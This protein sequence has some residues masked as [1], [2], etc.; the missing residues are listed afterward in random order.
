M[1]L[2][3]TRLLGNQLEAIISLLFFTS[4]SSLVD[5]VRILPGMSDHDGIPLVT[6]NTRP[7]LNKSK[8]RK[9]HQYHK[10]DWSAIKSDLSEISRDFLDLSSEMVT[11]DEMWDDFSSRVKGTMDRNI[12]TKIV[13][14]HKKVPW[15][16]R[17]VSRIY[18]KKK[19]AYIK[20]KHSNS[21]EDWETFRSYRKLLNRQSRRNYR[22]PSTRVDRQTLS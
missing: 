22:N 20:A 14:P 4:N 2:A 15:F 13:T 21:V 1:N 16:D 8:P 17:N 11:V 19:K 10:A 9:V 5:L 12:P 18:R 6:I 7:K 3:L